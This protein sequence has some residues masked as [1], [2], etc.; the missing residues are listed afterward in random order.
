MW[1]ER[2][3]EAPVVVHATPA[4]GTFREAFAAARASVTRFGL[5]GTSHRVQLPADVRGVA[6]LRATLAAP[7]GA[8]GPRSYAR[9]ALD[10][11]LVRESPVGTL[12]MRTLAVSVFGTAVP[13][14]DRA[15]FGG[16]VSGPGYDTHSLRGTASVSQRVEWQRRIGSFPLPLGR[17]GT[18]R[19]PI[20]AAPFVQGV[21]VAGAPAP[22]YRTI[23]LGILS[24]HGTVRV[25]V[26]R[27]V[28]AG[29]AW[30]VR[31]DA[32]RGF[33]PIL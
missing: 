32:A 7:D 15:L 31:L 26:A 20:V 21:I 12:A 33:W 30:M 17:F 2:V 6:T 28:D 27:G 8:T 16:P 29:G 4:S 18:T 25:D 24:L 9:V 3:A 19:V 10:A 22:V 5:E 14:Q 13:L 1:A 11:D 23:G